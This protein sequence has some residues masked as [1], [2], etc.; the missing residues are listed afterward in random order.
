[1]CVC[2][3]GRWL[4]CSRSPGSQLNL[5]MKHTTE[6][7]EHEMTHLVDERRRHGGSSSM[8]GRRRTK[9]ERERDRSVSVHNPYEG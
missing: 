5:L 3:Q 7:K 2:V 1:M 8:A 6:T 9:R 4:L